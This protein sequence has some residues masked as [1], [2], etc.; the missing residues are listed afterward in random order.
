VAR[1][2]GNKPVAFLEYMT[3]PILEERRKREIN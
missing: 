3:I 1:T 2:D